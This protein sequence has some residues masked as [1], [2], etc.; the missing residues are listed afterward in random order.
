MMFPIGAVI[1]GSTACDIKHGHDGY[2]A[3]KI[4]R[5][6]IW[7]EHFCQKKA[8]KDN[9]FVSRKVS[10]CLEIN[11]DA[12]F[13]DPPA[14]EDC[15]ICF[16]PMPA[17]ILS[18]ISLP[19]AT[20]ST[21]P[22]YDFETANLRLAIKAM[23]H[24]YSCCGK[25]ICTGCVHSFRKSEKCPF[26]NSERVSETDKEKIEEMMKRVEANDPASIYVLAGFHQHGRA[27]LQQEQTKAVELYTRAADLGCSKAHNEL[28]GIYNEGGDMK[29]AKFHFEAAAM[30]GHEG[31]R[32]NLGC[33]EKTLGN[34][35]RAIKHLGLAASA[36]H[37]EAMDILIICFQEGSIT[38]ESI[39]STLAAY[40]SSCA[41][42]RSEARD[43]SILIHINNI[44][45]G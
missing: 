34:M 43:T 22:I 19:P 20:I 11:P 45:A 30:A 15:P 33:L 17:R 31:A 9:C 35:E 4:S 27:S 42:M 3:T 7:R 2:F 18:C 26:C 14:K 36:G 32:Y 6:R 5:W 44:G 12:L 8:D 37:Y 40:N 25:S 28:G 10:A 16:L 29:K 23:T 1:W 24:F 38:R 41:E 39:D 13:K 21:V